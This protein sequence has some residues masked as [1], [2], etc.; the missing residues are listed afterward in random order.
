MPRSSRVCCDHDFCLEAF[1][2]TSHISIAEE[3]SSQSSPS[4]V[5]TAFRV[6]SLDF[7]SLE[8]PAG[9][10]EQDLVDVCSAEAKA[11]ALAVIKMRHYQDKKRKFKVEKK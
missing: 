8:E 2:N 1:G 10:D 7:I 11:V 3:D 6:D 9:V 4:V 5:V